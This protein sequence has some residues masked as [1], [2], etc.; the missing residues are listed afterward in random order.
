MRYASFLAG[1]DYELVHCSGA[2]NFIADSLSRF[3][4][5]HG[6]A[7]IEA[8]FEQEVNEIYDQNIYT[9]STVDVTFET[10]KKETATDPT[11]QEI[12]HQLQN[13][14]WKMKV[15]NLFRNLRIVIP[16]SLQSPVISVEKSTSHP[17]VVVKMKQL[18]RRHCYWKSVGEDIEKLVKSCKKC[19]LIKQNSAKVLVPQ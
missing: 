8:I 16:E 2:D 14:Q 6:I 13:G 15:Y 7:G 3:P 5:L 10:I 18:A 19:A 17:F 12:M 1:F 4:D 11:L 9:I